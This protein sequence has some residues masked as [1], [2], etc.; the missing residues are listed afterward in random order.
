MAAALDLGEWNDL[1]PLN[2][3]D[4]GFR[5]ALAAEAVVHHEKT[6]APGPI[7]KEVIQ[8]KNNLILTF[9]KTGAGL[10]IKNS[11]PRSGGTDDILY[12]T[13]ISKD[14]EARRAAARL[15]SPNQVVVDI[16]VK[17]PEKILYAWADNP[18]DRQLY[19]ADGLP[20]IPF[21]INI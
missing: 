4:V 19:N 13:V 11:A 2:K 5:L 21:N 16:P 8:E 18:A 12:V 7:L 20:A 17:N 14:K 1:H 3:K 6:N 10:V 15:K 9:D